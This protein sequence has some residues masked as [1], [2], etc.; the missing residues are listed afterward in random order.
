M[1]CAAR[2]SLN[3]FSGDNAGDGSAAPRPKIVK[4]QRA[5]A[6]LVARLAGSLRLTPQHVEPDADSDFVVEAVGDRWRIIGE[7]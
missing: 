7:G 6:A 1:T 2:S 4:L 3:A 5:H